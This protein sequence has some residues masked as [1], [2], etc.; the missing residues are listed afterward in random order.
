[1]VFCDQT[2]SYKLVKFFSFLQVRYLLDT[3]TLFSTEFLVIGLV[4]H[5][6]S[7]I[8]PIWG[9]FLYKMGVFLLYHKVS[10]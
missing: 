9:S 1:M 6:R 3:L 4:W 5:D 2:T 7:H 8:P 10:S